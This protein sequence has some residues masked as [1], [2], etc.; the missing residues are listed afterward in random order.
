MVSEWIS[1]G[2]S[3]ELSA[4]NYMEGSP[5]DRNIFFALI[6]MAFVIVIKRGISVAAIIENNRWM[7]V[8]LLFGALSIAWSDFPSVSFKRYVKELGNL[9]MVLV[10]LS[11]KSRV[12]AIRTILNRCAYVLIPLSVVLFKYYPNLGR[13]YSRWTGDLFVTGVT[14]NKNSLGVLCAVCGI[15]IAWNIVSSWRRHRIGIGEMRTCVQLLMLGV[16]VWVLTMAK[17]AT[18]IACFG[19]GVFILVVGGIRTVRRNIAAYAFGVLGLLFI[20]AIAG[21]GVLSM[22]TGTL[23]RDDTLTGRTEV[24]QK[25]VEMVRNPLIGGGYGSFWLGERLETLWDEYQWHP[26]EAH[27]GYLEVFLDL[28]FV[29]VILMF[30]II[31]SAFRRV[32]EQVRGDVEYGLLRLAMLV[33]A[34]LYNVTESAFRPGL[35]MY[36]M[37]VLAV[38]RLPESGTMRAGAEELRGFSLARG[39]R[40]LRQ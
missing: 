34:I 9:L 4:E 26:T 6:V 22:T 23:G 40:L 12:D 39:T 1:G 10:V 38:V 35:L 24:W 31:A 21:G 33:A 28:G 30:G 8:F 14:N 37:F 18:S 11:E 17:S 19:V 13:S 20:M 36:F 29:G 25:V 7:G 15:A 2:A 27:N 5:L 32:L 16:T 3:P